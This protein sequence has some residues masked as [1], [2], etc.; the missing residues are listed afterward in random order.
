MISDQGVGT[1][2]SKISAI[3]SWP[4]PVNVKELRSFLGLAG[5]YRKFVR[6]FSIISKPLTELLKKHAIFVW[7]QAHQQSF[8]ALKYA[9]I[10]S[11][12]LSLPDFSKPFCIETDAS[13]TGI[14]AVL[15]QGGHPLAF[16]SKIFWLCN[17]GGNIFNIM[18]FS[19]ALIK[20]V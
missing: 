11:P 16:L 2:P 20:E 10:N 12:V 6:N 14:G 17:N 1:D 18:N 13:G 19:F 15:L 4:T 9:L 3:S 8:S 5:Y 7:T